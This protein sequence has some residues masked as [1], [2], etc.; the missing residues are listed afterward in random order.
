[1]NSTALTYRWI[2]PDAHGSS[3]FLNLPHALCVAPRLMPHALPMNNTLGIEV[4]VLVAFC[5]KALIQVTLNRRG[6]SHYGVR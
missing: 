3:S 5:Y 1:M 4:S 2:L 6:I